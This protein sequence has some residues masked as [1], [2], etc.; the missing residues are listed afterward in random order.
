MP[1]NMSRMARMEIMRP[2]RTRGAESRFR[3]RRGREHY[4]DGRFAPMRNDTN[5]EIEGRMALRAARRTGS[6]GTEA[7]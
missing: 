5:I 1:R 4:D 7:A 6:G 3:D 2:D